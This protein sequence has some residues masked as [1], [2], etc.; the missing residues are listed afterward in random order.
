MDYKTEETVCIPE[1]LENLRGLDTY[2]DRGLKLIDEGK[3]PDAKQSLEQALGNGHDSQIYTLLGRIDEARGEYREA[4]RNYISACRTD[5][6]NKEAWFSYL[7]AV[8]SYRIRKR[9]KDIA[10]LSK[11]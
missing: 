8:R 3:Y 5:V 2:L 4:A 6:L 7:D 1:G 11:K 9:Q 10:R